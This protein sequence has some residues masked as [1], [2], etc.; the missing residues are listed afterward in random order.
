MF[1]LP[2][3]FLTFLTLLVARSLTPLEAASAHWEAPAGEE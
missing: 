2:E 1:S 3:S